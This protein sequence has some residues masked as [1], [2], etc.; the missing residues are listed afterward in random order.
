M[1]TNHPACT[2]R[3]GYPVEIQAL[4]IRLLRQLERIGGRTERKWWDELAAQALASLEK[5]FWHEDGGYYADVLLAA[6]GRSAA[7]AVADNALRSNCLF[8]I[9]LGVVSGARAQRCV[10]AA[11][12][13]VVVPGALR[14]LAPLP[15]AVPLPIHGND[16]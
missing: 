1:D 11:L 10:Q 7:E 15:V 8:P 6:Q 12:R 9:S 5:L 13:Y 4:W 14:S 2:P 3:E 16:G